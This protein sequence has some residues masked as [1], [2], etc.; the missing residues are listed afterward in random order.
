MNFT[1][2]DWSPKERTGSPF[3]IAPSYLKFNLNTSIKDQFIFHFQ[4]EKPRVTVTLYNTH[5][6][7]TWP[8]SK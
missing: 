1:Y 2:L 7:L 8:S 6:S 5:L 4:H 3:Y